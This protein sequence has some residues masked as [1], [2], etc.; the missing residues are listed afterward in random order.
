MISVTVRI[1]EGETLR[2]FARV[3]SGF[4]EAAREVMRPVGDRW[5]DH[6]IA[7]TPRG[8]GAP[9]SPR[10]H[11]NYQTTERYDERGAEYR[12]AN[13][14]DYLPFVLRGRGAVV[15]GPGKM[16]RFEIDGQ[17]FFRKRVGPAKAN[18]Y[19]DRVRR[20]MQVRIDAMGPMLVQALV[21]QYR[22]RP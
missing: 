8:R 1:I 18:P 16:L 21:R 6:L 10:L 22:G 15:A 20:V 5:R 3:R 12:I 7:E 4:A 9:H 19:P 2:G 11:A 17:V 13:D 14:A